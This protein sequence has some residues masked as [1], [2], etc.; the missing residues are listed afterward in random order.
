MNQGRFQPTLKIGAALFEQRDPIRLR[1]C[2]GPV[3]A[4]RFLAC[5]AQIAFQP[6]ARIG[7][8]GQRCLQPIALLLDR[9]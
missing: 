6:S 4:R 8:G 9:D 7:G 2:L 1:L 3:A 5:V